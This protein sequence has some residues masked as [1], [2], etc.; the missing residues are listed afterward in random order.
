MTKLHLDYKNNIISTGVGTSFEQYRNIY[1]SPSIIY[2]YDDL[3]VDSTAS[4]SLQ[5]QKGAFS[6]LSFAY[7]ISADYRDRAYAPTDGY[8][9]SF[10][11]QI[12]I[13]ADSPYI[14][15]SYSL[16]KYLTLSPDAIGSFKFYASA[17]NGLDDKDV[18]ISKR[19]ML[20]NNKLRGFK[21]GKIG[22]KDGEDYV[23]GNYASSTNFELALPN[24]LPEATK[25]DVGLFLDIGNVWA[26]DYDKSLDDSN[27]IRSSA[28]INTSWIS[29]LGPMTFVFSQ[30]L[31]KA[32]TDVTESFNF[33]L[34]TSF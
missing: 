3:S 2:S 5:K 4:A 33:K 6:D 29:P 32:K 18:R 26:V 15:N 21:S 30:N 8:I 23:G 16:S 10:S 11:Q 27:K 13:Y 9:S 14:R 24:L 1:L 34:G 20:S 12:P 17:I 28:G 31:S 19:V 25:T 22:P 7:G